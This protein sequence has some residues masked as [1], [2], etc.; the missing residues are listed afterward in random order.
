MSAIALAWLLAAAAGA[1]VP[2][3]DEIVFAVRQPGKDN[4]YYANFGYWSEDPARKL[5]G[6]GGQLCRLDLNTGKLTVLLDDPDGGV[7]DPEVHYDGRKVLFSYRK[8]RSPHYHLYE[9][10]IDG[11][12]L[13]QLT[14]GPFDDIEPA[15][16]PG[17]QAGDSIVFASSRCRRWAI[18]SSIA[19]APDESAGPW[20]G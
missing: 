10:G 12:G 18:W 7:R 15:Y 5:Y 8:G 4:H 20:A 6:P 16:L 3:V 9:I 2:G 1:E 13:R 17:R 14:D 11:G 19:C